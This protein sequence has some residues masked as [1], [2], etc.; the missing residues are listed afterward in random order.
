MKVTVCF[1]RTRVV[2][3]CGDGHGEDFQPPPA[4]GDPLPEGHRQG[5]GPG[6]RAGAGGRPRGAEGGAEAAREENRRRDQYGASWKG[7]RRRRRGEGARGGRPGC[8]PRPGCGPQTSP[9]PAFARPRCTF[10]AWRPAP[11]ASG[12]PSPSRGGACGACS[13]PRAGT[14]S[15][16]GRGRRPGGNFSCCSGVRPAR[17]KWLAGASARPP[18]RSC[19]PAGR[20][21]RGGWRRGAGSDRLSWLAIVAGAQHFQGSKHDQLASGRS[22]A[23]R[24]VTGF[25]VFLPAP[26][27]GPVCTELPRGAGPRPGLEWSGFPFFGGVITLSPLPCIPL[28]C[29]RSE[30]A[31]C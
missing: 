26:P 3:P 17:G 5:E 25:R 16:L 12:E 15:A 29:V 30:K 28:Q 27:R 4:S 19:V 2:V 31:F 9:R 20:G 13:R 10:E 7:R 11:R 23:W 14:G 21:S 6:A 24:W 8:R 22:T 1:R 18:P